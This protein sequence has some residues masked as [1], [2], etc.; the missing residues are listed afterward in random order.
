MSNTQEQKNG[1]Q[2]RF[3][4]EELNL[5]K[6]T[7]RGNEKLLKLMRKVFLPEIDPEAPLG[8]IVDLWMTTN[9]NNVSPEQAYVNILARNNLILHIE[10]QLIQLDILSKLDDMT[11]DELLERNKK[12]SSK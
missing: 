7:F 5:I 4:D 3:S 10:Q 6:T 12:N 2:M 9:I 11:V 1:R 8:Q